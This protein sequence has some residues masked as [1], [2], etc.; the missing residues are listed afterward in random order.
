MYLV[1][2][3]NFNPFTKEEFY[4]IKVGK[5]TDLN[6]RMR[7]Y[8]T[9]NPMLWKAD[10]K[11]VSHEHL[12]SHEQLCHCILKTYGEQENY[13]EWYQVSRETYLNICDKGFSFFE[14]NELYKFY[15]EHVK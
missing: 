13:S 6:K 15:S 10:Y 2:N 3:T 7:S 9:H 5:T 11:I 1:G 8:A 4:W 12:N 14:E